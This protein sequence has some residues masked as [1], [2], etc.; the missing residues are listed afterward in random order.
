LSNF[1]NR[2]FDASSRWFKFV[3]LESNRD[4]MGLLKNFQCEHLLLRAAVCAAA[5]GR[6]PWFG[7]RIRLWVLN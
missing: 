1:R 7:G 4:I 3:V 5:T 2:N 6:L